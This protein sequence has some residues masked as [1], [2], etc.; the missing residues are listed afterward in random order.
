MIF[1]DISCNMLVG[2]SFLFTC[3]TRWD[4]EME[5]P[6]VEEEEEEEEGRG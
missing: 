1:F 5:G 6:T 2:F 4:L 3:L